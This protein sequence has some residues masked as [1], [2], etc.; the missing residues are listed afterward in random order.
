MLS[1]HVQAGQA[2]SDILS[3]NDAQLHELRKALTENSQAMMKGTVGYPQQGT[4][5]VGGAG[6]TGNL[7]PLVPQS[8][9]NTIDTASFT[10]SA[11]KF[12]NMLTKVNVPG[13]KYEVTRRNEYSSDID[14]FFGEGSVPGIAEATYERLTFNI[15]Y[16]AEYI[17]ITD[18]AAVTGI[19]GVNAGMLAERTQTGTLGLLGSL[20][21]Y[22]FNAS[23]SDSP[24]QFDGLYKQL[25]DGA[26]NNYT[27]KRGVGIQFQDLLED[28]G[29]VMADPNWGNVNTIMVSPEQYQSLSNQATAHGR[30][31]QRNPAGGTLGF[32]YKGLELYGPQGGVPIVPCPLMRPIQAPS[33]TSKGNN[34]PNSGALPTSAVTAVSHASSLWGTTDA[35]T[36][37]YVVIGVG[38][39]GT[40]A[41]NNFTSTLLS[42]AVASGES[43]KFTI[44][45][46][47]ADSNGKHSGIRYYR[48][49]RGVKDATSTDYSAYT[50]LFNAPANDDGASNETVFYDHNTKLPNTSPI[51]LIQNTPD[52]MQWIQMIDFMRRPLAQT[53]TA[54]PFLLMMFGALIVKL[55]RK[56]WI[57]DNVPLRF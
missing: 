48:V 21:R 28:I 44:T 43:V 57:I 38:D 52:V 29:A 30:H 7:A 14:K 26:P 1:P 22:L 13:P 31:D 5:Y 42:V 41:P 23:S 16:L 27:D 10:E 33:T 51:Y 15:K 4:A 45:D 24:L 20:E 3:M 2:A 37:R 54:I 25:R 50:F 11:I 36:Y 17:E 56:N 49:Y 47:A 8:I 35:G 9:Q 53:V 6:G 55:P 18:V 32:G 19:L 12:W 39:E 46:G 34:P 40:T